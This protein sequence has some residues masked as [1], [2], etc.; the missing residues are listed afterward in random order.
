MIVKFKRASFA[1]LLAAA[2]TVTS[3][4]LSL[5]AAAAA[6]QTSVPS[7]RRTLDAE[8]TGKELGITDG[9]GY[10]YKDKVIGYTNNY[11][12]SHGSVTNPAYNG[13]ALRIAYLNKN[14]VDISE[15]VYLALVN[16][17]AVAHCADFDTTAL[18]FMYN[19]VMKRNDTYIGITCRTKSSGKAAL[20]IRLNDYIELNSEDYTKN[21]WIK[22]TIPINYF[23][24]NGTFNALGGSDTEFRRQSIT[25]MIFM[26]STENLAVPQNT[27]IP[28][29]YADDVRFI[30]LPEAPQNL[31]YYK[32]DSSVTLS[33][34]GLDKNTAD[35]F[36]VYRDGVKIAEPNGAASYTDTSVTSTGKY[37]Y[38]VRSVGEDGSVSVA[39][40]ITVDMSASSEEA[41]TVDK[42]VLFSS[43]KGSIDD[44][45]PLIMNWNRHSAATSAANTF[46]GISTTYFAANTTSPMHKRKAAAA[47]FTAPDKD[48][49]RVMPITTITKTDSKITVGTEPKKTAT[50]AAAAEDFSDYDI[51]I[52]AAKGKGYNSHIKGIKLGLAYIDYNTT[53]SYTTEAGSSQ[54]VYATGIAWYDITSEF[55]ALPAYSDS[56]S[57]STASRRISARVGDIVSSGDEM[58]LHGASQANHKVTA[59]NANAV[60]VDIVTDT[61]DYA[62]S[63]AV[64]LLDELSAEKTTIGGIPE[65]T[66]ELDVEIKLSDKNGRIY[67]NNTAVD[68]YPDRIKL[69]TK[70]GTGAAKTVKLIAATYS[71]EGRMLDVKTYP[72]AM[73]IGNAETVIYPKFYQDIPGS[74]ITRFFIWDNIDS[75]AP[76]TSAPEASYTV[77][78]PTPSGTVTVLDNEYQTITGWGISPFFIADKDFKSFS[79]YNEWPE[80][81]DKTY[82]EMGI[83]SVRVPVDKECGYTDEPSDPSLPNYDE[84]AYLVKYIQRAKDFGIDDWILCFWSPPPYMVEKEYIPDRDAELYVLKDSYK[85][86][87]C[88]YVVNVLDYLQ[89]AGMGTPKGL[90]FQNEPGGGNVNPMYVREKYVYVAKALRALLNENG[91]AEVPLQ[92]PESSSYHNCFRFTGGSYGNINFSVMQ[93]DQEYADSIGVLTAH[94]YVSSDLKDADIARFA[95]G[96]ALYPEKERWMT[97]V[98][99]LGKADEA[100]LSGGAYDY[101][102]GPALF[103]MRILSTDVGWV[104]MNRW[105]YWRAYVSHYNPDENGASYD[106]LNDQYAQQ[107][108]LYGQ[109]G[110]K[111]VKSK[112]YDC[113]STLFNNVPVGSK[114][115]RLSST[116]ASY[117]NK[118]AIK[119]DLLAFETEKGTVVMLVN[120]SESAK[121]TAIAGLSGTHAE[122]KSIAGGYDGIITTDAEVNGGAIES[123]HI[124]P[125]SVTFV[126]TE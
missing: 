37:I 73:P 119:T 75:I 97:E 34:N 45:L 80:M 70:N 106:V 65:I 10:S 120:K 71:G 83:T 85:D 43:D 12:T 44:E 109:T 31:R 26:Y 88:Q 15:H 39:S 98:S 35:K 93:N 104:G 114:V 50:F 56:N 59:A 77:N 122:I 30:E 6:G 91:Y 49:Y 100:M 103:T 86:I 121:A 69:S 5:P 79:N 18:Q 7:L 124:P 4:G 29:A 3:L 11:G 58:Y 53:S 61:A 84:L 118:C 27:S 115:K 95:S 38:S 111:V 107:A 113:L 64:I 46:M 126:I 90:C 2:L 123:V 41:Y 40:H 101:T 8:V 51:V 87:Y 20:M 57:W 117:V 94:T 19:P 14:S 9:S 125:R 82:G 32:T 63:S 33:W 62:S 67:N 76:V 21:E 48:R 16:T 68:S 54:T 110:G 102:M 1:A 36:A 60:V 92:G 89:N 99:G 42:R 108:V 22:V 72:A 96:C 55:A 81:Y 24:E 112:L 17:V 52:D 13:N 28:V 23:F 116:D 25:G 78:A 105:Y 47:G 66:G 74:F